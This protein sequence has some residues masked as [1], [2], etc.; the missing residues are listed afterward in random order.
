MKHSPPLLKKKI[1]R[2]IHTLAALNSTKHSHEDIVKTLKYIISSRCKHIMFSGAVTIWFVS[3]RENQRVKGQRV[4]KASREERL[5]LGL[6]LLQLLGLL[7]LW[8]KTGRCLQVDVEWGRAGI[9]VEE[10]GEM[11]RS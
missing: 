10:G 2:N 5:T 6:K 3:L 1:N 11:G 9:R 7:E 4:R 8:L